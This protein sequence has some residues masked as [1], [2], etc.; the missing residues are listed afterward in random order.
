[1]SLVCSLLKQ[2][3]VFAVVGADFLSVPLR[4]RIYN[5]LLVLKTGLDLHFFYYPL[6]FPFLK[7]KDKRQVLERTL[8]FA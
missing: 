3:G 4:K 6:R 7:E 8:N 1:M 2:K 5:S